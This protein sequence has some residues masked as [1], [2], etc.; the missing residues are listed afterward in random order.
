MTMGRKGAEA[1]I[2][3]RFFRKKNAASF[4]KRLRYSIHGIGGAL[5]PRRL[6][7]RPKKRTFMGASACNKISVAALETPPVRRNKQ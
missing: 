4:A 3:S 1:G 2:F 7:E 6:K 5:G